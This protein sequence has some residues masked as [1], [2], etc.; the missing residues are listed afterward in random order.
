MNASQAR[1]DTLYAE[2]N[3][4]RSMIRDIAMSGFPERLQANLERLEEREEGIL[5][6]L[7]NMKF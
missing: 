3:E 2:L 6:E 5:E 1:I 7:R 4:V